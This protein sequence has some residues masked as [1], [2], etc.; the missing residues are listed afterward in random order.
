MSDRSDMEDT[1]PI[2]SLTTNSTP[3]LA[4][5]RRTC[6]LRD[7]ASWAERRGCVVS[8]HLCQCGPSDLDTSSR[9]YS[10]LSPHPI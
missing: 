9:S 7:V 3:D 8:L 5:Y 6:L 1:T 10:S 4:G 2:R